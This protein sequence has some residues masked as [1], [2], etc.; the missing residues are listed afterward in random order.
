M[1]ATI[2]RLVRAAEGAKSEMHPQ[3]AE[4]IRVEFCP[5]SK[6]AKAGLVLSGE[7]DPAVGRCLFVGL[8]LKVLSMFDAGASLP[9]GRSGKCPPGRRGAEI[10]HTPQRE[11][12]S[13]DKPF[14]AQFQIGT[15]LFQNDDSFP[16]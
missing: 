11:C 13:Y 5:P 12:A 16:R 14:R 1:S 2:K 6:K 9:K 3:N 8:C 15:T 10:R 4:C 7:G